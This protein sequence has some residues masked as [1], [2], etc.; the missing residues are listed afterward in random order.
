MVFSTNKTDCHHITEILLIVAIKHHSPY[1]YIY[2]SQRPLVT[3]LWADVHLLHNF[4]H[5][6]ELINGHE[7]HVGGTGGCQVCFRKI[8]NY[9]QANSIWIEM[10]AWI[11]TK[12][13]SLDMSIDLEGYQYSNAGINDRWARHL[14]SSSTLIDPP[15]V[16]IRKLSSICG[17][18][19]WFDRVSDCC[20]TPTRQ[21]FS[22][23]MARTS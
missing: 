21:F 16:Q 2:T 1:I 5:L 11:C 17:M 15:T 10:A 20:W 3:Q 22:Y 14:T 18:P 4:V 19:D 23:I 9:I 12:L 7:S 6:T 8:R 13:V